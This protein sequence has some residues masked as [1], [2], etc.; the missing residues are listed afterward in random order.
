MCWQ[1]MQLTSSP[2]PTM[3][4]DWDLFLYAILV[5]I[6]LLATS[7]VFRE[8]LLHGMQQPQWPEL[9]SFRLYKS[10][11]KSRQRD[12]QFLSFARSDMASA[13]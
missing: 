13:R 3:K 4:L 9:M 5:G 7:D 2:C 11:A 8:G 6:V 1:V 10:R 12:G